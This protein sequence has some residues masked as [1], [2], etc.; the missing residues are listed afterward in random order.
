MGFV[1]MAHYGSMHD[2]FHGIKSVREIPLFH[3]DQWEITV[4]SLLGIDQVS[5]RHRSFSVLCA[6]TCAL[7]GD[8]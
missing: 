5:A 4:P 1:H 8:C 7:V 3:G 6:R 2:L